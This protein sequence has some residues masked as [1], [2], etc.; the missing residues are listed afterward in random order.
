ML[1]SVR[2]WVNPS[3][4]RGVEN[5]RAEILQPSSGRGKG[6]VVSKREPPPGKL[7]DGGG[8]IV[9]GM[10]GPQARRRLKTTRPATAAKAAEAM[11]EGSGTAES[12][13]KLTLSIPT[14]QVLLN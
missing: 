3:M 14:F 11:V 13:S 12:W 1:G 4:E 6:G 8:W 9:A 2:A 7:T 5:M 10:K